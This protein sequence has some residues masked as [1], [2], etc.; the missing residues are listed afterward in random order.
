[1]TAYVIG[2]GKSGIAAARLLKRQGLDVVI[3]DRAATA[4]E[5]TLQD[6]AAH[7]ITVNL[8]QSF[9][10]DPTTMKQIIVSPG[11]PWDLPGLVNARAQGI[12]TLRRRRPP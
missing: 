2:L 1:M 10:P 6:L 8:G 12:E 4:P 3:S 9:Q 7:G 11:V 5:S